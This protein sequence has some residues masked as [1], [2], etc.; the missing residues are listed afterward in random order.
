VTVI[1]ATTPASNQVVITPLPD[2]RLGISEP[3]PVGLKRLTTNELES[4]ASRFYDG[5]EAF[6]TAVHEA[7]K[8]TK[9][10]RAVLR[11][12]RP[13]IEEKVFK[14]EDTVMRDT[15]RLLAPVRESIAM[16]ES[17]ELLD[18]IY[19]HLLAM[20]VLDEIRENLESQR[21]RIE[22]RAME[23]PEL[24]LSVVERFERAHGRYSNWPDDPSARTI[25]G[26]GV[27]DDFVAVGPGVKRT[28][29]HGRGRMVEAYV[30]K[31]SEKLHHWRKSV[32][33]LRHQMEILTPLWPEVVVGMAI[34][35]NRVGEMLGQ[36]H[37]LAMLNQAIASD[38]RLCP[39]PALRS[40]IV[41]LANQRRA[42]LQTAARIL[43]RRVFVERPSSLTLR[44]EA[45]WESRD[46]RSVAALN[47]VN[48]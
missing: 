15:A 38:A 17:I 4:A 31:S 23:D 32:R 44:L 33:Y 3:L 5:E 37:D 19:G 48:I 6:R 24:V 35:L 42:D 43:G 26:A 8:S 22:T 16:V 40:L 34:T 18:R 20:N 12:I 36:D 14:F 46:P 7:R 21:A 28:Y 1:A 25:Y 11:M 47:A 9:R 45:Y 13:E 29:R 41:A 39:D 2:F 10:V 30:T 27:R